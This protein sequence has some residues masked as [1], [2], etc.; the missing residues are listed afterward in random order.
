LRAKDDLYA[1]LGVAR[2]ASED[3]IKKAYR[4]LA[5]KLHPDKCVS[6]GVRRRSGCAA[7]RRG[8]CRVVRVLLRVCACADA[9]A[10]A[11]LARCRVPHADEAFKAVSRAFSCL[12][13]HALALAHS[14]L[15]LRIVPLPLLTLPRP[16]LADAD[17][18]ATFDRYGSEDG[19][20]GL[21]RRAGGHGSASPFASPFATDVDAEDL[22]RAFFGGGAA[23]GG[24]HPRHAHAHRRQHYAHH[25]QHV[26]APA[27][28]SLGALFNQLKPLLVIL[29]FV[30][31]PALFSRA[32]P[33]AL[34]RSAEHPFLLATN[35]RGV[36]FY[37]STPEAFAASHPPGSY[38]RRALEAE[39]EQQYGE[40]LV[41]QCNE[42]VMRARWSRTTVGGA[43]AQR[44]AAQGA[45]AACEEL[46]SRYSDVWTGGY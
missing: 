20:A 35:A 29:L 18:R 8:G 11:H 3:E 37:V 38:P 31:L 41:R 14:L 16:F 1:V 32:E 40:R 45:S 5:L 22:F 24:M 39:L 6:R 46:R 30:A 23:F 13:A 33:A 21:R 36:P 15:G 34:A 10:S 9:R 43:Q 27:P 42:D 7:L 28:E 2:G 44:R 26:N 19:A 17:K 25:A 12:C 4:K